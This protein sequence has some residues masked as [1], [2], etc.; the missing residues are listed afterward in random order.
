[1]HVYSGCLQ[2]CRHGLVEFLHVVF[3][4]STVFAEDYSFQF[5]GVF[6]AGFE[7]QRWIFHVWLHSYFSAYPSGNTRSLRPRMTQSKNNKEI[8]TKEPKKIIAT[9]AEKFHMYS[10]RTHWLFFPCPTYGKFNNWKTRR[11]KQGDADFLSMS[12]LYLA[13][14]LSI[15]AAMVGVKQRRSKT[16]QIKDR[17]EY[18]LPPKVKYRSLIV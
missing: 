6:F 2:I 9:N 5:V 13:L 12:T 4:L 7:P 8:K 17:I 18:N 1:M 16:K 10:Q 11:T 14:L 3:L 15:F